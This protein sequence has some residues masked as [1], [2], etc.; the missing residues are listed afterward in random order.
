MLQSTNFPPMA[1]ADRTTREP[2]FSRRSAGTVHRRGDAHGAPRP[3]RAVMDG[4]PTQRSPCSF[5][6]SFHGISLERMSGN[7]AA[8]SSGNRLR[9]FFQIVRDIP[10]RRALSGGEAEKGGPA[11]DAEC[12]RTGR[13][14]RSCPGSKTLPFRR[15]RGGPFPSFR[16]GGEKVRPGGLGKTHLA[17]VGIRQQQRHGTEFVLAAPVQDGPL[18]LE[19]VENA[20]HRG[21]W[22]RDGG[23]NLRDA[24]R[25]FLLRQV[26]QY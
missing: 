20:V 19:A 4:A 26:D 9:K 24:Q 12:M 15:R 3:S 5:C 2:Y 11:A 22:K 14:F 1:S 25:P 17:S 16:S 7:S 10:A 13:G 6:S 23:C 8:T 18:G 21:L